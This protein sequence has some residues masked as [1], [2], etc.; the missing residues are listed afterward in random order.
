[1]SEPAGETFPARTQAPI[2]AAA[3][4]TGNLFPMIAVVMPLWAL[5]LSA[6]PFV[7]GL[8]IASRQI[9][10]ITLSIHS[11]ALMD[12]FGPRQ[13]I[14]VMGFAGAATMG[15]F[16]VLP[17]IWAAIVLQVV[18][19][20]SE[21]T[22]WIGT[23]TLV[24]H[25]LKGHAIYAGRMTA[26]ARTGGFA[27]PLLTGLAWD[28]LGPFGAFGFLACWVF[29]GV[30]AAWFVP[31]TRPEPVAAPT[32][33]PVGR[34]ARAA[35]VMPKLSDYR[36]SFRLLLIPTVAL[37]I[38]ATMMRQTGSGIQISFYSVWLKEIGFN[39]TTIGL[40]I[41]IGNAVSAVAALTIGPLTRRFADR[42]LLI[43][44]VYE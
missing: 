31:D 37:V 11:G 42:W 7:I 44:M 36:T 14:L 15:L 6:S 18:S 23:Q 34:R 13:V 21:T 25:V 17:F 12:R 40:L 32:G 10:T 1:M 38:A 16:P 4:F 2:Y 30:I 35:K 28:H 8:I 41:G 29:C 39:G 19:G 26:A 22:N 9:L 20:F 3:F 27:G 43:A 5:E 33:A 24:G